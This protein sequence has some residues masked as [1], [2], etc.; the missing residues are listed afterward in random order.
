M[1]GRWMEG[2][3]THQIAS[4]LLRKWATW[5]GSNTASGAGRVFGTSYGPNACVGVTPS[6]GLADTWVFGFGLR[7]A[8]Q[9]TVL[10]SG[11]Q[12]LYLERGLNEQ[13]HLEFVNNAGSFE[14]RLKRGSTTPR[15]MP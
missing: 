10:N 2:F 14:L 13:V 11:A 3:E 8:S 5:T 1:A 12:G 7:I 9:Q 4:Q 15:F 6:L